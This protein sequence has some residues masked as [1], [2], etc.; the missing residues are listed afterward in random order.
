V[1]RVR[2]RWDARS[3]EWG[4]AD[5]PLREEVKDSIR[6]IVTELVKAVKRDVVDAAIKDPNSEPESN[7][8]L[9]VYIEVDIESGRE[10]DDP[11]S[12]EK[13][14]QIVLTAL[15]EGKLKELPGYSE[16]WNAIM[17]VIWD[18]INGQIEAVGGGGTRVAD[19][20]GERKAGQGG[21]TGTKGDGTS[22]QGGAGTQVGSTGTQGGGADTQ[23]GSIGTQDGSV[24]ARSD[25]PSDG[26]SIDSYV[27][28]KS[29]DTT[30][31]K[32]NIDPSYTK[33]TTPSS[34]SLWPLLF[35]IF[36]LALSIIAF[37]YKKHIKPPDRKSTQAYF[38]FIEQFDSPEEASE[39][40]LQIAY[41][42]EYL[43]KSESITSAKPIQSFYDIH[44]G[45]IEEVH[46]EWNKSNIVKRQQSCRQVA[47]Y[48][49]CGAILLHNS[50]EEHMKKGNDRSDGYADSTN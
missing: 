8:P 1:D 6:G 20:S 2:Q 29:Q 10:V 17:D 9:S 32:T 49:L 40:L 35:L 14:V 3:L 4:F 13:Y 46:S 7:I 27:V 48:L 28:E 21:V 39:A 23:R 45:P 12:K 19:A 33:R 11:N 43:K 24:V 15:K 41:A 44:K 34:Y 26:T 31:P 36:L 30:I 16:L 5:E 25:V 22:T 50:K 18:Y 42:M 47:G 37:L 38:M